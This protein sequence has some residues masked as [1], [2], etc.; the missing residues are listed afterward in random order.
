[1]ALARVLSNCLPAVRRA[2]SVASAAP[3]VLLLAVSEAAACS[4]F[5]AVTRTDAFLLFPMVDAPFRVV[6]GPESWRDANAAPW[7]SDSSF[8]HAMSG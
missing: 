8:A 6:A 4:C 7:A 5:A 3:R 1:M 2:A